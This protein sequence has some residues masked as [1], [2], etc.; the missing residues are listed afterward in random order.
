[1]YEQL[2]LYDISDSVIKPLDEE[3]C[4]ALVNVQGFTPLKMLYGGVEALFSVLRGGVDVFIKRR[5]NL[6]KGDFP[7]VLSSG[8]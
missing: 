6:L 2:Q 4:V 7:L 1:L 8:V 5:V 3:I